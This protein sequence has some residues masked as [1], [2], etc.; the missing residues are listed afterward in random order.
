M[1]A[2]ILNSGMGSRMGSLTSDH[3][4]CMTN[5]DGEET[6]LSRQLRTLNKNN[7]NEIVITT[8]LFDTILIEYCHSL[9]LPI[10]YKFVKNPEYK[11]T[12]YIYSIYCARD[13]L[14]DDILLMHGDLVYDERIISEILRS[15]RSV[16]AVS[17]TLPLPEKDFKAVIKN[18]HIVSVGVEFFDSAVEA[19]ALYKLN[20]NTWKLWLE[21]IINFCESN[22]SVKRKCYAEAAL[23]EIT[24]K[25]MIY[26]YDCKDLLCSEIDDPED[27]AIVTKKLK[28]LR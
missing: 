9:K 10:N 22:D 12:N 8:G 24:D 19:Q 23:N 25:C 27:L 2:L 28:A 17:S 11:E 3:P 16:M 6:I 14:N 4:K 18:D 7:I 21:N 1:R 5:I 13:Q 20:F 15:E 26:P